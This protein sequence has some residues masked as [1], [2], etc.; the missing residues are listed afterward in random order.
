MI[1]CKCEGLVEIQMQDPHCV[2]DGRCYDT[3]DRFNKQSL[4]VTAMVAEW[5]SG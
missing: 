4:T 5:L 1:K 2:F 3:G